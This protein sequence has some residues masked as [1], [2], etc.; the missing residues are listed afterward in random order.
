MNEGVDNGLGQRVIDLPFFVCLSAWCLF[1]IT[2]S[3]VTIA[4]ALV[5]SASFGLNAYFT[6]RLPKIRWVL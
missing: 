4:T 5:G 2:P 6:Y 3:E 1:L